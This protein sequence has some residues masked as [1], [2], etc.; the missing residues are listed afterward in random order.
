M[1][2]RIHSISFDAG[3]GFAASLF[4]DLGHF[5]EQLLLANNSLAAG[6]RVAP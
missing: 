1:F 3:V 2:S 4:G 5:I 6:L